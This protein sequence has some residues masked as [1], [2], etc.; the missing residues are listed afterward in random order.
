[1]PQ[2]VQLESL[3]LSTLMTLMH[4]VRHAHAENVD[5]VVI[6][7]SKSKRHEYVKVV[8]R[9][10]DQTLP[11]NAFSGGEIIRVSAIRD[12]ICDETAPDIGPSGSVPN[13]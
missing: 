6:K 4:L 10:F 2:V 5:I 7:I 11:E 12:K 1:V 8:I 3:E 13:E 9:S